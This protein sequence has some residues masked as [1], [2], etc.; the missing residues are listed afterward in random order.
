MFNHLLHHTIGA[1]HLL[2]AVIALLAGAAVLLRTKGT[3]FHVWTGRIYFGAM[4]M[5]NANA[6]AIYELFGR[7]GPFHVLALLSLLSV[8]IGLVP[9]LRRKPGWLERHASYVLGSWVDLCAAAV[10]EISS[11]LL[12]LPFGPTVIVS[13]AVVIIGGVTW[14]RVSLAKR[15][16]SPAAATT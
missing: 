5:T 4:L 2:S 15:F 1:L 9:V 13:F 6:L 3:R 10:A 14:M 11:H 8:L 16:P 7:F 12:R